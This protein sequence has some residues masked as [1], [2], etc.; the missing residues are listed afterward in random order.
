M[1]TTRPHF[2]RSNIRIEL[3]IIDSDSKLDRTTARDM[4]ASEFLVELLR[5]EDVEYF[6]YKKRKSP[7]LS[8][9]M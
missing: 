3:P 9:G 2:D 7:F 5:H 1:L 6:S 4:C 8:Q